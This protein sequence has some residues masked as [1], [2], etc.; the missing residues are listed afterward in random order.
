[1][2]LGRPEFKSWLGT[3]AGALYRKT[4]WS[5]GAVFRIRDVLILI[6]ILIL[7]S[8]HL[9]TDPDLDLLSTY[10]TICTFTSALKDNKSLRSH[11]T[12]EIKVFNKHFACWWRI[13]IRTNNYGYG[14]VSWRPRPRNY[15]IIQ[16]GYLGYAL[17]SRWISFWQTK[18]MDTITE[19]YLLL[20]SIVW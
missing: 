6:R 9:I 8:V 14:F 18:V 10:C 4:G 12:E 3:Q 15:L 19:N 7:G 13:R 11:K 1:M 2:L 5:S 20:G 17:D 16:K